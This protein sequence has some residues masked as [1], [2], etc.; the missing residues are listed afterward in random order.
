[1][2]L[3]VISTFAGCGGS[4]LGYKA[5]GF[6]E[7][8]AVDF[9]KQAATTFRKNFPGIPV[10]E[11]DVTG[12]TAEEIL[13]ACS[14][15]PGELDVLDGSPPC[16]GFSMA[17]K[18]NVNDSRND[19]FRHYVRLI[20]GLQPKVFVME[21]VAGMIQGKMRGRFIEITKALKATGYTVKCKLMNAAN[22]GVPQSRRRLIWIGVRSDLGIEPSFPEASGRPVTVREALS[23][24]TAND[25]KGSAI[26]SPELKTKA[27]FIRQGA[28]ADEVCGGR[29]FNTIRL[30]WNRPA[31]TVIKTRNLL[32][33][34]EHRY[35]SIGECKR[36]AS[37]PD[38]FAFPWNHS[39]AWA[40]IGNA[41][42]PKFM[43]AVACHIK[44]S[45]LEK[46]S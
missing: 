11:R 1:M 20:E 4:S 37:F 39:T 27:P 34:E 6:R 44:E 46:T 18:R 38:S 9:N 10:W 30:A 12:V 24:L 41:V 15:K 45:I 40:Q 14:L 2:P 3:T 7:L 21:N 28:C 19:L 22:Y 25:L 13:T 42:M 26:G 43:E 16:Q 17:G 31:Q 23:G 8:L 35:L 36:I 33:P 32:H 29:Y 5:A